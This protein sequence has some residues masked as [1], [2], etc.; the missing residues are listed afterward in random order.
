MCGKTGR[1]PRGGIAMALDRYL[2]RRIDIET[3]EAVD[4]QVLEAI[5]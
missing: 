3:E 5:C 4:T 1:A 2:V